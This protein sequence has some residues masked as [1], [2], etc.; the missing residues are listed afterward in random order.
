MKQSIYKQFAAMLLWA[1]SL[2]QLLL[3]K[4]LLRVSSI[5]ALTLANIE[6]NDLTSQH[7]AL[8][9][10]KRL[11]IPVSFT[12]LLH[13]RTQQQTI[14]GKKLPDRH[15]N[16][17]LIGQRIARAAGMKTPEIYQEMVP[18]KSIKL[19]NNCVI[20]PFHNARSSG[21]FIYRNRKEIWDVQA[22]KGIAS[23]DELRQRL[24][25]FD[26]DRWIVE[27][28]IS[29]PD[30]SLARDIKF[31]CCYGKVV[32]VLEKNNADE[33]CFWLPDNTPVD[34]GKYPK[35]KQFIGSGFREE[36]IVAVESLSHQLPVV[37]MRIDCL[38]DG[39]QLVFGEFTPQPGNYHRINKQ[40][41]R[42]LGQEYIAAQQRL[43][44]DLINGKSFDAYHNNIK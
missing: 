29:Q 2:I 22:K 37:F 11:A 41:D 6:T 28:L 33:T 40:T 30:G 19:R 4:I 3:R 18:N 8:L 21:V 9:H 39:E 16:D 15:I 23:V 38:D 20:K 14:A 10:K 42:M 26:D 43:E 17:K 24:A 5:D 1:R 12:T 35:N 34:P 13:Y 31:Y 27:E 25:S 36:D 7:A 44:D 32:L